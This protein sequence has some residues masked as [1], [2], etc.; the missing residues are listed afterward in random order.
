MSPA[1]IAIEIDLITEPPRS[2]AVSGILI[3]MDLRYRGRYY[4]GTIVGCTNAAGHARL[5]YAALEAAFAAD[6]RL[7]PMDY[8][9]PLDQCDPDAVILVEGGPEFVKQ[10]AAAVTSPLVDPEICRLW[11]A[12][13]NEKID[14]ART[15]VMLD[16]PDS[17]GV[18]R[19][20]LSVRTNLG[21]F[22]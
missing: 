6:Q 8:R 19:A 14:P 3:A 15:I 16:R 4:Y 13:S 18:I 17:D 1:P 21:W 7:S 12:A 11:E 9:I 5:S 22:R 2:D 10:R 20:T